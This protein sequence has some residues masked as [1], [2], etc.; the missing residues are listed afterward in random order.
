MK[1]KID[2]KILKK[3]YSKGRKSID[4]I[5]KILN[6]P[7]YA[8]NYWRRKYKIKRL[9]YFERHPLPKL[10]KIQKEYLFGALLGGDRLGKKKE[11]TYPSLRIGHSIKQKDY[12]FW[13]YNIWKNL[14]LS[15]VKKV[16]IR[17]KDKTYFSHQFFTREHPE[18]LK[19]YNFFYK[20][21]K[22]KISREALNQLT[23]FSIAIWYMD[24]GSYIKSRGRALLATNS[25]SYKE[26]LI[27]QKY[28][29]E[30]WNL[31][32]TIGTS[33]SGTHYLRFNTENSI[34][35]LKIIEKYIIPCFHYKIDPGRK[36]LYRKLSAEELN[37]IKNNYKTKSPKL[38]AQKL[39]RD[40]S[41]IRNIIR[42]LKLTNLKRK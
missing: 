32:T 42:R 38:I 4:D 2:E 40:A 34:K 27:I 12:V 9:T 14:V 18:F 8:I 41:N 7:R 17:V 20:N 29:K 16:K 21:G 3:L 15:G 30:K 5:A 28:F 25:F 35:F 36:L 24:D 22:K 31:P 10:T 6:T 1:W 39:K 37:Y 23:P 13:K 26:Q 33:D 19:F 11:E